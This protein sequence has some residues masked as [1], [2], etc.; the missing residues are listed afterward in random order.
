MNEQKEATNS[1]QQQ[2]SDMDTE[3]WQCENLDTHQMLAKFRQLAEN[4]QCPAHDPNQYELD[5]TRVGAMTLLHDKLNEGLT[6]DRLSRIQQN[7]MALSEP[8]LNQ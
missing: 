7:I 8:E 3:L 1:G 2:R 6:N 5:A 4:V